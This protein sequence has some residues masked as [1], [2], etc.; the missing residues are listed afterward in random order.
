M[1]TPWRPSVNEIRARVSFRSGNATFCARPRKSRDYAEAYIRY[2]APVF[3]RART[4][5]QLIPRIDAGMAEKGHLWI[6]NS[7]QTA[8][9]L[10]KGWPGQ[11]ESVL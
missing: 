3:V 10:R 2:A 11:G 8:F 7:G 4:G 9:T 5:R 1:D 6:R